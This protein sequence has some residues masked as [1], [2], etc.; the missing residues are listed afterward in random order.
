[1]VGNDPHPNSSDTHAWWVWNFNDEEWA[2]TLC[3]TG[4]GIDN[5]TLDWNGQWD[6]ISDDQVSCLGCIA[7]LAHRVSEAL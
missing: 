2:H 1:M 3:Y 4:L 7:G 6:L 5:T